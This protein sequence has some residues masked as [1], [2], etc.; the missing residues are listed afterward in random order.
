MSSSFVTSYSH[1]CED[2]LLRRVFPDLEDGFFIDVGA[3]DPTNDSVTK[4]FYDLGWAGINVEPNPEFY[5]RLVKERERDITLAVAVTSAEGPVTLNIVGDTGLTTLVSDIA[6]THN[7]GGLQ[8]QEVTVPT[9]SLAALWDQHVPEKQPVHFLKI[10]VEGAE[11]D[12]IR[13]ADWSRHRPWVLVVEATLPNTTISN[14]Q[15]WDP[16]LI[17]AG[18]IFCHFDRVNRYYVAEEH[19]SLKDRFAQ[20][21]NVV[22]DS[23]IPFMAYLEQCNSR[24]I[25]ENL[26]KVEGNLKKVDENLGEARHQLE[27]SKQNLRI[28]EET[29]ARRP[30][31]IW[32]WVLFYKHGRPK[33]FV[34]RILF[35]RNGAPREVFRSLI[36]RADGTP[37][38][39]FFQ[40]MHSPDYQAMPASV[41]LPKPS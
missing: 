23:Y 1:T 15:E 3:Y 22:L 38:S 10:D 6:D 25:E 18:Y 34:R 16:I 9:Q 11:A 37:R 28:A 19:A 13:S 2:V 39:G 5:D 4:L 33:V 41:R 24:K 20:P 40:W 36:L 17:K 21:L 7:S 12:V 26:K 14:H 32:E 31:T 30:R 8:V 29:L 27:V 35:H